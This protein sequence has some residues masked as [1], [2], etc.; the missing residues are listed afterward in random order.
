[1]NK[2]LMDIL[3]EHAVRYP[4]MQPTDAVKLV[5]QH[6]M[7]GGHMIADPEM[8]LERLKAEG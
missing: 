2:T 3:R 6:V 7:G 4:L 8:S 5:Y 1:M